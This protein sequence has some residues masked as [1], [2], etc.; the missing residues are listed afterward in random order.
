MGS[1]K[2]LFSIVF[3]EENYG[4]FLRKKDSSNGTGTDFLR[5]RY[6]YRMD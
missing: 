6:G 4:K 2:R 3:E 5:I 1:P